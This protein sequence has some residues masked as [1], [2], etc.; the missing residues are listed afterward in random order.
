MVIYYLLI[1]TIEPSLG[2]RGALN[3]SLVPRLIEPIQLHTYTLNL[4]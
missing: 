3:I 4:T 1:I 2:T